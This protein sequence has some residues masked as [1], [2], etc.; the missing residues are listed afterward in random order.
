MFGAALGAAVLAG[1]G[2]VAYAVL[3][4]PPGTALGL[5]CAAGTT[6]EQFAQAGE[7]TSFMDVRSGDPVADCA[8]EYERREGAAPPRVGYTTGRPYL[9]VVPAD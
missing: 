8:A 3:F 5:A 9:S 7:L 6:R 1:G 2:G 4:E